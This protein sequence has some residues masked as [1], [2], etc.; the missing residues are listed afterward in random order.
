M[1]MDAGSVVLVDG[2]SPWPSP[3]ASPF[4]R[5][6][7]P[8]RTRSKRVSFRH[9]IGVSRFSFPSR[10]LSRITDAAPTK[11]GK[12]PKL[13]SF[14]DGIACQGFW[15]PRSRSTD[16]RDSVGRQAGCHSCCVVTECSRYVEIEVDARRGAQACGVGIR[17]VESP[18]CWAKGSGYDGRG[19]DD[20]W[21]AGWR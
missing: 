2:Q 9:Q 8:E 4:S 10:V 12:L 5:A 11:H 21:D 15:G 19:C 16:D 18:G 1:V 20:V 14:V 13:D 17:R 7:W 6:P 3:P